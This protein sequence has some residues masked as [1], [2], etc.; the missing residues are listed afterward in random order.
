VSSFARGFASSLV[1]GIIPVLQMVV[2]GLAVAF[3]AVL[4]TV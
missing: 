1:I 4:R 2:G 3:Q